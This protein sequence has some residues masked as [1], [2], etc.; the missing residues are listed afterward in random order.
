PAYGKLSLVSDTLLGN[1]HAT[2]PLQLGL[3]GKSSTGLPIVIRP[4]ASAGNHHLRFD[5]DV[6]GATPY[7]FSVYRDITLGTEDIQ[8]RWDLSR[9]NST[10][11]EMRIELINNTTQPVSFDCRV[12]PAG[13]PY[14]RFQ[15]LAA[16]P[17]SSLHDFDVHITA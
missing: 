3:G 10:T 9:K 17:G 2:I 8:F 5:V 14:Q 15:I 12:F 11:A 6:F 13:K 1:A 16:P 4:D 7:H